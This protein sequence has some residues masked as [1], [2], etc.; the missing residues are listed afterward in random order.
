MLCM[1]LQNLKY[2]VM[3]HILPLLLLYKQNERSGY[4]D[5][6]ADLLGQFRQ[7]IDD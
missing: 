5:F 2:S 7:N 4:I 6:V 1:S 3:P